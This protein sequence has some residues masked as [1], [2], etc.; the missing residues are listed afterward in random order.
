MANK[1]LA[2][3]GTLTTSFKFPVSTYFRDDHDGDKHDKY[4]RQM[5]RDGSA[6]L[7]WAI[8]RL[9][10]EREGPQAIRRLEIMQELAL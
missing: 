10:A 2:R 5:M 3:D 4:Y 8:A 9:Q 6:A 7:L 1:T